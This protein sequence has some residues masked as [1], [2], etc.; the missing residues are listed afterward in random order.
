MPR[1]SQP[2]VPQTNAVA[3]RANGDVL[4]GAMALLVGAGL[5]HYLWE[6]AMRCYRLLDSVT[7]HRLVELN[8][9]LVS[10]FGIPRHKLVSK[11]KQIDVDHQRFRASASRCQQFAIIVI[12]IIISIL[13]IIL[14][15]LIDDDDYYDDYVG[16][17]SEH[18]RRR[19]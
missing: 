7:C 1:G 10:G 18:V 4:A 6:Y 9:F 14:V 8:Y 5:P 15:P 17:C 11:R 13:M 3:E 16:P 2:G 19:I 12:I